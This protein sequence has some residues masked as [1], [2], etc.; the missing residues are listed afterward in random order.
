M[1]G[2]YI[3]TVT[4]ANSCVANAAAT[5]S[6]PSALVV[7]I[8]AGAIACNGGTTTAEAVVAGG[9]EPYTFAWSNGETSQN[10]TAMSGS[11][12]VTVTDGNECNVRKLHCDRY[13]W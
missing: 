12:I 4:D 13:R 10:I 11:Y 1:A 2:S 9:T 7:S 3:V 8:N 6:E 5:I